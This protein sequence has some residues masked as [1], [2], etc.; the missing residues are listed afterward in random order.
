MDSR[1]KLSDPKLAMLIC[2]VLVKRLGGSVRITQDD[3]NDIAFNTFNESEM[4][5]G[6]LEFQLVQRRMA[7]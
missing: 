4:S 1:S 7:G 5:D 2:A 3:I 6:S